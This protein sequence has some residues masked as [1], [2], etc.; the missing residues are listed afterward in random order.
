MIGIQGNNGEPSGSRSN[1]AVPDNPL[2]DYLVN[3]PANPPANLMPRRIV[4]P[5]SQEEEE[6]D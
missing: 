4:I 1:T 2:V 6:D 3:P 5:S